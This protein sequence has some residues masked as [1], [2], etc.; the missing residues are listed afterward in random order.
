VIFLKLKMCFRGRRYLVEIM[1]LQAA[2]VLVLQNE[3]T[4]LRILVKDIQAIYES[5]HLRFAISLLKSIHNLTI[6]LS[7][8]KRW[9]PLMRARLFR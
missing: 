1:Y 4:T 6:S 2:I 7:R 9:C 5:H 3:M 8:S